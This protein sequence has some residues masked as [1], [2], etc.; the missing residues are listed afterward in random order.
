MAMDGL[1]LLF[2]AGS[3]A[4]K[5]Y[6]FYIQGDLDQMGAQKDV[7]KSRGF[8]LQQSDVYP[9][10][11]EKDIQS[12]LLAIWLTRTEGWWHYKDEM[13]KLGICTVEEWGTALDM[14]CG[15][16]P[17]AQDDVDYQKKKA[18]DKKKE[19]LQDPPIDRKLRF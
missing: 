16:S 9:V 5:E 18:A 19:N 4:P 2:S 3:H 17:K 12:A 14:Q 11:Q 13:V 8:S 7:L 1:D 10:L 15:K 6:T